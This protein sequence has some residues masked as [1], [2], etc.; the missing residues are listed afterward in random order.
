MNSFISVN[1]CIKV[2]DGDREDKLT[3]FPFA[4]KGSVE[5]VV[6]KILVSKPVITVNWSFEAVW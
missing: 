5:D 4:S 2:A 3:K 1:F 6:L